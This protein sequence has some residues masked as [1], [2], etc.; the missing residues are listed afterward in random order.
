MGRADVVV[1]LPDE[2]RGR[3]T[4][5]ALSGDDGAEL[6]RYIHNDP[7]S[8]QADPVL[9]DA[10]DD[11]LDDVLFHNPQRLQALIHGED[12]RR[13]V[14]QA[15][16]YYREFCA[17]DLNGDGL[18]EV[19]RGPGTVGIAALNRRNLGGRWS[20]NAG[21][22]NVDG[23]HLALAFVDDVD[24]LDVIL[25]Y[26]SGLIRALSGSRGRVLWS[27]HLQ[28]GQAGPEPAALPVRVGAPAV[29]D[30]DGD[31]VE[32]VLVGA[33]DGHLYVLGAEGALTWSLD[34]GVAVG[35]P[36]VV[37][38]DRD[39]VGEV[40][41]PSG[42]GYLHVLGE[43]SIPAPADVRDLALADDLTLA[44]DADVDVDDSPR[45]TIA[46]VGVA[47]PPPEGVTYEARIV[48]EQ[49][50]AVSDWTALQGASGTVPAILHSDWRYYAEVRGRRGGEQGA[51]GRSDGFLARDE[52]RP[53]LL[54]LEV[55]PPLVALDQEI[56]VNI[57]AVGIDRGAVERLELVVVPEDAPEDPRR[58]W[59]QPVANSNR[60]LLVVETAEVITGTVRGI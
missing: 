11:G 56:A 35:E 5:I 22:T 25:P 2:E 57:V 19:L 48:A 3:S 1:F 28:G 47:H 50:I 14:Q 46:G 60:A 4:P 41:V 15:G 21:A 6:W 32:D 49:G 51:I 7:G 20:Y 18:P 24:G 12:G 38:L 45:L 33:S 54:S 10:D 31:G 8:A 29:A 58:V 36:V 44:G 16:G 59:R 34:F 30:V 9:V 23:F 52:G 39:G 53:F 13:I 43:P 55:A 26:R 27:A 17:G 40:V 37:D 42:D